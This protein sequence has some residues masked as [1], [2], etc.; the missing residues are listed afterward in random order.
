[1]DFPFDAPTHCAPWVNTPIDTSEPSIARVYDA[2]LGGKDNFAADREVALKFL[3]V[4]GA[5]VTPFDN[6]RWLKR[7]TQWLVG[8]ARIRQII[9]LGSG[10]PTTSS[11]HEFAGQVADDVRVVYVDNDPSVLAHGRALLATSDNTTVVTGDVCDTDAL[12]TD[13]DLLNLIDVERPFAVLLASVLHHLPD[14]EDQRVAA[15]LRAHLR[16]G[17][18]LAIANF[19][20]PGPSD[21]R[22]RAIES[23]LVDGGLGSGWVRPWPQHRMYFGDLDLVPPGLCP[24]NE[25]RPDNETPDSSPVHHLY[26]GGV[27]YRPEAGLDYS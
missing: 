24:V 19:H 9:D 22:A 16:P 10:L 15:H 25:W 27:G 8:Q 7:V 3:E 20:N 17:C 18:Y 1:M 14:G 5:Q 11:I 4:P 6:R 12:L 13:P 26:I 2:V 21:P 23:A